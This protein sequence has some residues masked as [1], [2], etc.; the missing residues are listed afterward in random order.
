MKSGGSGNSSQSKASDIMS[1]LDDE[2]DADE[3]LLQNSIGRRANAQQEEVKLSDSIQNF[4]NIVNGNRLE[5]Y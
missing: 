5:Y 1:L 2:M 4:A 3:Q